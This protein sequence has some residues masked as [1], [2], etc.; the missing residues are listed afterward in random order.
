MTTA[1]ASAVA[2]P[3]S[4]MLQEALSAADCIAHQLTQDVE[5]YAGLGATLRATQLHSAVTVARGSSD[6]ASSYLAYLIMARMGRLVTSLPMSLITLYKSPIVARDTLA[7]AIS[8][9]GQSPD[10]VEPIRYFRDGGATTVALV[11]DP[12]SPLADAAEWTM[13]LHAGPEK[14]VA[15]TKSFIASLVAGARLVADWQDS[16]ELKDGI[17]ALPDALRAA[18]EVDWSAAI[19]VLA[20]AR[21]IMVVGRGISFPLALES[22]LKF[23]E[24]SALQAEAFSG[25]EIKHGPMALI[26]EGYPLLVYATR[27]PT[28]AGLVALADEMRG[29]GARVL[30]AAPADVASRDLTLP[31]AAIPDLDPIAAVQAFY[32]M[33]AKLA[34]AR[35]MNPDQPRHLSKVTKTN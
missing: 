24:T 33:A 14:S 28:Q 35:G 29:R 1:A 31:T 23:K 30:L 34:A 17:D 18:T 32:T 2:Q 16:K 21:N 22:S 12:A 19:E 10:V 20:P 26:E 25:A 27:G 11:N 4:L 8:Q 13:P 15:A 9:S 3:P 7:V 5:R 6:H